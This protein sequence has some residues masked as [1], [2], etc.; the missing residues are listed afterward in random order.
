MAGSG[1]TPLPPGSPHL[2]G[3]PQHPGPHSPQSVTVPALSVVLLVRLR[4][5]AQEKR[6]VR[7]GGAQ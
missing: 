3:N 1:D 7:C 2:G 6:A 4:F 5:M